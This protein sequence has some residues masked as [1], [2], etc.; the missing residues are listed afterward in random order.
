MAIKGYSTYYKTKRKSRKNL[1]KH[2][3]KNLKK[4]TKKKTLRKRKTRK[5]RGGEFNRR[6]TH[7]K[8]IKHKPMKKEEEEEEDVYEKMYFPGKGGPARL[9][10]EPIYASLDLREPIYQNVPGTQRVREE[11]PY[12]TVVGT[13]TQG[14]FKK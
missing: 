10:N 8:T 11:S 2:T 13:T 3:K 5:H 6:G 4:R 14:L 1:K 12:A 9:L 7:R